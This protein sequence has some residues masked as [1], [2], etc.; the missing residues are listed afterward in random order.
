[1]RFSNYIIAVIA[2]IFLGQCSAQWNDLKVTWG[3]NPLSWSNFASL[4]RTESDAIQNKWTLDKSC[5]SGFNGNRYILNGDRAVMLIFSSKGLIAGIAA[6]IP[7]N[8]PFNFPSKQQQIFFNDEVSFWSINAYFVN[9]STVCSDTRATATGDRL[10]FKSN[11]RELNVPVNEAQVGSY[12][13]KGLC[14]YTMGQHYWANLNGVPLNKDVS[15]ADFLPIFLLYN[16][17]QLNGFGWG[18]NADLPSARYEHPP[19]MAISQFFSDTPTFFNDPKQS[20]TIST[21]HIYLD[22]TPKFNFC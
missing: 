1:M 18:F 12:W 7:K 5:K 4:P 11:Q 16:R 15:S 21:L 9:P 6:G 2:L 10:V 3:V 19:K 8:L 13:T 20:G 22:S 14:F 17:G